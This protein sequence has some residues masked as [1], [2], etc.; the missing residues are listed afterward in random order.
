MNKR[1]LRREA[2]TSFR[3]NNISL[4]PSSSFLPVSHPRRRYVYRHVAG[5]PAY[6]KIERHNLKREDLYY[7]NHKWWIDFN[8][9]GVRYVVVA[10]AKLVTDYASVPFYASFRK[11]TKRGQHIDEEALLHDILFASHFFSFEDANNIFEAMMLWKGISKKALVKTYA[12]GPRVFGKPIYNS[13][14]PEDHW[15]HGYAHIYKSAD[16]N[17]KPRRKAGRR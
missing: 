5:L 8:Y 12:A 2:L 7:L 3:V 14:K 1:K 16:I 15:I 17:I 4:P 11:L 9:L 10:D 13:I 6:N